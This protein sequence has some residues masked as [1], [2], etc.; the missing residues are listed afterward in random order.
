MMSAVSLSYN[1]PSGS[2]LSFSVNYAISFQNTLVFVTFV[3]L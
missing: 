2:Y 1:I 3:W